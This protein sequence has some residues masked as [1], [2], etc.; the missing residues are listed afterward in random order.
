MAVSKENAVLFKTYNVPSKDVL[1]KSKYIRI[2][3]IIL[4]YNYDDR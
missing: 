3:K 1:K 4:N 2:V